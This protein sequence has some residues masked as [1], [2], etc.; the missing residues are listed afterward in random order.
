MAPATPS[1]GSSEFAPALYPGT[2]GGATLGPGAARNV[3][4]S[5]SKGEPTS[6][7]HRAV[8]AVGDTIRGQ[9]TIMGYGDC[10]AL[11][12]VVLLVGAA[13][14]ALLKK[15]AASDAGAH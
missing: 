8:I 5:T 9:A 15:G 13:L 11:L 4:K 6:A 3:T 12:G 7:M 1:A 14:V 10:F 2:V